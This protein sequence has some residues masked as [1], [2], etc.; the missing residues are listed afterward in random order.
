MFSVSRRVLLTLSIVIAVVLYGLLLIMASR[1]TL[2]RAGAATEHARRIFPVQLAEDLPEPYEDT[3]PQAAE[4]ITRPGSVQDLLNRETEMLTPAESLLAQVA[5][6]PRMAERAAIDIL[7][8][9]HE[10]APETELVER[11]DAQIIEISE[12]NAR[13]EVEVARRL[14]HPSA[15]RIIEEGELPVMRGTVDP[16]T[17]DVLAFA[18]QPLSPPVDLTAG[19]GDAPPQESIL[20]I[21]LA[22]EQLPVLENEEIVAQTRA[23]EEAG[24]ENPYVFMDDLVDIELA[25]YFAPDEPQGFFRLRIVPKA[26]ADHEVLGKDITFVIDASNSIL[27]RKLDLTA[28]GLRDALSQLRPDDRFN[29]VVFRDTAAHFQPEPVL[30]TPENR[31]A[32]LNFLSS[33]QSRG[34]TDIYQGILPVV[35]QAPRP[36][37]PGVVVVITDGRATTGVRDSRVIINALSQQNEHRNTILA[38]GGGNTVNTPLLDL[39]AYRNKGESFVSGSVESMNQDLPVFVNRV[40]DPLLVNLQADYGRISKAG[41]YPKELP[42]FFK[43]R[44]VTVYGRFDPGADDVFS[45]RLTGEAGPRNKEVVFRSSLREAAKGDADIARRWAFERIYHLIGEVVRQGEKPELVREIREL[46]RKHGIKTTYDF[47]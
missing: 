16:A 35:Q 22:Q 42:D 46:S 7:A 26:G 43:N 37:L 13:N 20:E 28:R 44:A 12:E 45:M 18:P 15:N 6:V 41:V 29:V 5:E 33:L 25:T 14:V 34:A 19:P 17:R 11:L 23:I 4:L 31:Q 32:A 10:L 39:L 30:A 27:Q 2:L 1:I 8:R 3:L 9:E 24:A 36:G 38:Y 40:S 47:G 21:D